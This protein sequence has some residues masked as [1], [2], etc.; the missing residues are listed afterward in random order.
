MAGLPVSP[1]DALAAQ[2]RAQYGTSGTGSG[3]WD[4]AGYDR[5]GELADLL[6]KAGVTDL[7]ELSFQDYTR[8][9]MSASLSELIAKGA[10]QEHVTDGFGNT[11]S[12]WYYKDGTPLQ[13][14][15]G[16]DGGENYGADQDPRF[17]GRQL[18]IGD[19]A[20]GY[21]GDYNNDGTYGNKAQDVLTGIGDEALLG[22]SAR[23]SGNTSYRVITDPNTGKLVISPGWNSS[24]DAD[25]FQKA[26][27]FYA[28]TA[29]AGAGITAAAGVGAGTGGGA[30]NL[31]MGGATAG[32]FGMMVG[33]DGLA[34]YGGVGAAEAAGAAAAG[35]G[36]AASTVPLNMAAIESGLG[37]PGYSVNAAAQSSGLFDPTVIG[38]GSGSMFGTGGSVIPYSPELVSAGGS[39]YD[40][41][42]PTTTPST[43]PGATPGTTPGTTPTP[44][45]TTP[46]PG[47]PDMSWWKDFGEF[48]QL[49]LGAY[50]LYQNEQA[51]DQAG[52]AADKALDLAGTA[53]MRQQ[54]LADSSY[55]N[56]LEKIQPGLLE[57]AEFARTRARTTADQSDQLYG[58]L[59]DDASFYRN[60][61]RN[62]QVPLEDQI[63]QNAR[64]LGSDTERNRLRGLATSDV[65]QRFADM[66]GQWARRMGE[67]GGNPADGRAQAMARDAVMAETLGVT[68]AA[69]QSDQYAMDRHRSGMLDA[70]ALGRGLPGFASS[71]AGGAT[72]A[73]GMGLSAG[74]LPANATATA[75]NAGTNAMS[76]ISNMYSDSARTGLAGLGMVNNY[77]NTVNNSAMSTLAGYSWSNWLN[78]QKPRKD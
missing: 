4:D 25:D 5:A 20:V 51:I 32:D 30:V 18:K 50:G 24:S 53:A 22:W 2:I 45:G 74:G 15:G 34:T 64:E 19:K 17:A 39:A 37:T 71:A 27:K 57:D 21:L 76:G 12:Q 65:R 26:A 38:S 59:R 48:G 61:W 46:P 73:G 8:T 70:A 77:A 35:A 10:Y 72:A 31:G 1:R 3:S 67:Y 75:A 66:Q 7:G 11:S 43:T 69:N 14:F 41:L 62:T 54:D 33:A 36:T 49:L 29:A 42:L 9:G 23:G 52:D 55:K 28:L 60:R 68:Q 63:I 78:P 44:N 16:E 47:G 13:L 58:D 56:Y 40:A 6:I